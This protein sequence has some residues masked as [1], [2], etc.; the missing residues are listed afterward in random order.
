MLSCAYSPDGQR[1]AAGSMD[2]TVAVWDVPS[3]KLL[4]K[5]EGHH[6]PVR[7]LAFTPGERGCRGVGRG[8]RVIDRRFG[9]AAWLGQA[10]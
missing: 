4:G 1:L 10:G 3:A 2:G 9:G 8:P 6:K 5:C 7:S